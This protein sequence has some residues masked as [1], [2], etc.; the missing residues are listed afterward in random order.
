MCGIFAYC[1]YLQEKVCIASS[2]SARVMESLGLLSCEDT[3]LIAGFAHGIS[4]PKRTRS[5]CVAERLQDAFRPLSTDRSVQCIDLSAVSGD[6][7]VATPHHER[8]LQRPT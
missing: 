2:M 3:S 8:A 5:K 6:K 1:S 4:R 7:D